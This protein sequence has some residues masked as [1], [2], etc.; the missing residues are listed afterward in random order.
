M[1]Y[2]ISSQGLALIKEFEGF[3]AEPAQLPD[4]NWL[5]GYGH[6]RA[7]PGGPVSEGEACD[8]LEMDIASY[9]ALVNQAATQPLTQAQ[10]DALVSF[11]FSIGAEA[12]QQSQVLRRVNSGDMIAAACA[13]E[14]WRKSD[15]TG[16]MEI[17]DA[18]V[19]RRAAEKALFLADMPNKTV[20]SVFVRAKLDH[21]A[22]IL[23]APVKYAPA[24]EVGAVAVAQ[25]PKGDNVVRL[26]E[27][28]QSE[29]QTETLLLTQVVANDVTE[30]GED[31][32]EIA[33]AHARPVARVVENV[34]ETLKQ[35]VQ[36]I[37]PAPAKERFAFFRKSPER[38]IP[39]V[40]PQI[41]VDRRLR[42]MRRRH[43]R[44]EQLRA[45]DYGRALENAGLIALLIFGLALV[46]TGA[47]L[48]IGRTV[49]AIELAGAAA[50]A[51]PGLAA[52][53]MAVVG[54]RHAPARGPVES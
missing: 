1:T 43:Q 37:D 8:L 20:P 9:E 6:V 4:G 38:A 15:V 42:N 34:R 32:A 25:L 50:L 30:E 5:V 17:V 53:L 21:A 7:E 10:F 48:L 41:K 22:S 39:A 36:E 31:A 47:S 44:I 35:Q 16:E 49:D 51:T 29:P 54:L 33:T 24:P 2:A 14:A 45:F 26:T 27:I 52:A 28:L 3:R 19:R 12:F 46:A 23:G 40:N 11:A 13:M 18:L